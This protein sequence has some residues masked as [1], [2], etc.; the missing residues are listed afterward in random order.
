[1]K[2]IF[3]L[4]FLT[5]SCFSISQEYAK[6]PAFAQKVY[7]DIFNTMDNGKVNK[8]ILQLSNAPK[9]IATYDPTGEVPIILIGVNFVQLIRNFGKD[10]C[11]ALAHVLGHELAHVILRQNDLMK[12]GSGYASVDFNKKVKGIQKIFKDSIF[13]RQAD[14]YA[15]FYAHISGYNTTGLG[16]VLLDSIY[17][18]FNLTDAKL[19]RYPTLLERKSISEFTDKKMSAL[20]KLYDASNLFVLTGN[21]DLAESLYRTIKSEN[22]PSREINNNIGIINLIKGIQ[23]LDSVEYPYFFPITLDFDTRLKINTERGIGPDAELYLKEAIRN[24]DNA[25]SNSKDYYPAYLNRAIA[26]FILNNQDAY[27]IDQIY[28]KRCTDPNLI[29]KIEVLKLIDQL[30]NGQENAK[31]ELKLMCSKGNQIACQNIDDKKELK[32]LKKEPWTENLVF[33]DSIQNPHFDFRSAEARIAGDSLEK[34]LSVTKDI[35]EYRFVSKEGVIG[36]QWSNTKANPRPQGQIYLIKS[37]SLSATDRN[38]LESNTNF[39]CAFGEKR[40]FSIGNF[41]IVIASEN[42]IFYYIK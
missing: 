21:F 14:E 10:S 6:P 27:T 2:F 31:Q 40:Y 17:N 23:L 7:D 8:P 26:N 39:L 30:H 22:F 1:M 24:F 37:I 38:V 13:E 19:F 29:S 9:E 41:I 34:F 12:T 42:A 3:F 28:L 35:V 16:S 32:K 11:N 36:E 15:S 33:I 25:I 5:I 18:R 4:F 20:K